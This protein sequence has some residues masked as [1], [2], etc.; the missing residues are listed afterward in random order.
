[1]V[2]NL[3][4]FLKIRFKNFEFSEHRLI[5]TFLFFEPYYNDVYIWLIP[6][7]PIIQYYTIYTLHP[8]I[9]EYY[10]FDKFHFAKTVWNEMSF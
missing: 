10:T 7:D 6:L 1:M 8:L 4:I 9:Y 2:Y 5:L 3:T